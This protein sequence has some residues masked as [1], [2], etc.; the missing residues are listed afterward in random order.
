MEQLNPVVN[1]LKGS[2]AVVEPAPKAEVAP[3][4][5]V[6][7]KTQHVAPAVKKAV[8]KAQQPVKK[9][10]TTTASATATGKGFA[11]QLAASGNQSALKK[12]AQANGLS[13]KTFIYKSNAT[14]LFVLLYGD[15]PSSVAAKSNITKLPRAVQ[16]LKP[17]P[18]SY[19]QVR[20]EQI[21]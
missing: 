6:E 19:A 13:S 14:G 7:K 2:T 16:N 10:T 18:K 17:W 5:V 9:T 11:L 12:L 3:A 21:K 20:K 15:Y 1:E 4:P 8:K